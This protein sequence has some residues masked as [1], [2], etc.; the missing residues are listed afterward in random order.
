MPRKGQKQ[1]TYSGEEKKRIITDICNDVIENKISFNEAVSNSPI[2]LVSFYQWVAKNE[3]L[4]TL[5][6]YARE[7]R[8]DF[9]FEEI[10]EIA[11]TTEEGVKLKVTASGV[12]ETHGDMTEH[13]KLRID[14]R[15][16][17]VAKMQPKKYGDK[18]DL[19]SGNEPL[20]ANI[21]ITV[22]HSETAETLKRLRENGS[23]ADERIPEN[24]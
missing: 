20:K 21:H 23:T 14:A 12:E 17:V 7:V 18:I 8:S 15:K 24:G 11:D 10:V 16:W 13:R 1:I 6:K 2:G 19:T 9:L 4:Q 22:D 3:E 5:Y